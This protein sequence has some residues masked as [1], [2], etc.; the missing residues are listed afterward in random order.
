MTTVNRSL[1]K[2]ICNADCTILENGKNGLY[3]GNN[4]TWQKLN[5]GVDSGNT[6]IEW[7][8]AGKEDGGL[9]LYQ[10]S[11]NTAKLQFNADWQN[12]Y[13]GT[14]KNPKLTLNNGFSA[15]NLSNVSNAVTLKDGD[16]TLT[17]PKGSYS[18]Q[19][20]KAD[21]DGNMTGSEWLD[22]PTG[23]GNYFHKS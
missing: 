21:A 16:A 22:G 11:N 14:V 6:P 17:A 1:N 18:V 10:A 9:Y 3:V 19:Y 20:C 12:N 23:D 15:D 13:T 4:A 5:I 2:E 8:I 7:W